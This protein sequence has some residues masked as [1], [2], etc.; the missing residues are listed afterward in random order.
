MGIFEQ[1][2]NVLSMMFGSTD[3]SKIAIA[4]QTVTGKI[5]TFEARADG[6]TITALTDIK[7]VDVLADCL[8][9]QSLNQ[10]E[11]F[12]NPHGFKTITVGAGS[13]KVNG[14]TLIIS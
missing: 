1:I 7:K 5:T 3:Y 9:G 11:W 6:T 2:M 13:I 12:S 4:G 8:N 10:G 14:S